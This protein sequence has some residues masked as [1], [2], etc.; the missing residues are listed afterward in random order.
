ML[1]FSSDM[2][3]QS[4]SLRILIALYVQHIQTST[5]LFLSCLFISK[6]DCVQPAAYTRAKSIFVAGGTEDENLL[7]CEVMPMPSQSNAVI[8]TYIREDSVP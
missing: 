1:F 3:T 5:F 6:G 2:T 4:K 7:G 8:P